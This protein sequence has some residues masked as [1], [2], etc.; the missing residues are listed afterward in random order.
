MAGINNLKMRIRNLE[1]KLKH[2]GKSPKEILEG[3]PVVQGETFNDWFFR[4]NA[5]GVTLE[6]IVLL[7]YENEI[8]K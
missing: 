2:L 3:L 4:A 8:D 5:A 1:L 6:D 7:S